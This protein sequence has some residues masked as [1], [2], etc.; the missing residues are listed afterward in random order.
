MVLISSCS[1]IID[2]IIENN[3]NDLELKDA[4]KALLSEFSKEEL[5][6]IF[7]FKILGEFLND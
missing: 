5:N 4:Q 7:N 6:S 2:N 3:Y 1:I